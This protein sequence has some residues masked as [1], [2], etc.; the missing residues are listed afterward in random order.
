MP[1][2]GYLAA[3]VGIGQT[4]PA[5]LKPISTINGDSLKVFRAINAHIA[6][7]R[8][9]ILAK[10]SEEARSTQVDGME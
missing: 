10:T 3:H 7:W 5:H 1:L 6:V 9:G 8:G 2:P 4:F